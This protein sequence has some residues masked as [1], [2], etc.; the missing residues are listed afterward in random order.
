LGEAALLRAGA[1]QG[2]QEDPRTLALARLATERAPYSAPGFLARARAAARL[3]RWEEAADAYRATL[4]RVIP[5]PPP[6]ALEA[7]A[8]LPDDALRAR[9]V[10]ARP[11]A[12]RA[13]VRGLL[14]LKK[15]DEALGLA[16]ELRDRYPDAPTAH[17]LSTE[18]AL[19]QG[20]PDL[21]Q[22]L[23]AQMI[24]AFPKEAGGYLALAKARTAQGDP[25]DALQALRA[26]LDAGAAPTPLRLHRAG[27]LLK[28][29]PQEGPPQ[30][31]KLIEQDLDALRL[32]TLGD[33]DQRARYFYLSGL[34][35]R[36]LGKHERARLDFERALRLR[37]HVPAYRQALAP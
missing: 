31:D 37:P 9:S 2:P 18:M 32:S 4:E 10:P 12:M 5:A 22:L 28:L 14:D 11:D 3:Q 25:L 17:A 1:T 13:A 33:D 35:Q 7:C 34:R 29:K 26:G 21:A 15:P 19:A 23:A 8:A 24:E 16:L 6:L 30:A 20:Q 27:L 36:R